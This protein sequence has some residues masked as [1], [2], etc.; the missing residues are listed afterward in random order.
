MEEPE[1]NMIDAQLRQ[2]K[3]N[4]RYTQRVTVQQGLVAITCAYIKRDYRNILQNNF[5]Y[6]IR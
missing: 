2:I 4:S 6:F 1:P 3:R 5:S